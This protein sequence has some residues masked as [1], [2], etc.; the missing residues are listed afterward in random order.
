M[1]ARAYAVVRSVTTELAFLVWQ[2][3]LGSPSA[4]GSLFDS[5]L[6]ARKFLTFFLPHVPGQIKRAVGKIKQRSPGARVTNARE[7]EP[8]QKTPHRTAEVNLATNTTKQLLASATGYMRPGAYALYQ[9]GEL[10]YCR[11]RNLD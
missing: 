10:H 8:T 2:V 3:A 7:K 9:R 5:L 4:A 11:E 1:H 6:Q